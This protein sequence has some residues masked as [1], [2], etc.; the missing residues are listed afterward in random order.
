MIWVG[1]FGM[2]IK[3]LAIKTDAVAFATSAD[4]KLHRFNPLSPS[5]NT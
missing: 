2:A 3:G 1:T 4:N 5:Q